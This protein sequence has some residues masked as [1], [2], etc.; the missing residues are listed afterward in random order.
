MKSFLEFNPRVFCFQ[1]NK[2]F[3]EVHQS[4][5]HSIAPS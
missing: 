4:T 2:H 5:L 1:D 3:L